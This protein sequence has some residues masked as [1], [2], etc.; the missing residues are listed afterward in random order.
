MQHRLAEQKLGTVLHVQHYEGTGCIGEVHLYSGALCSFAGGR[1]PDR[2]RLLCLWF[3]AKC[4]KGKEKERLLQVVLSW[5]RH[6]GT[7][8]KSVGFMKIPI[9]GS[10]R[11][12]IT[13]KL[14]TLGF[15]SRGCVL[16]SMHVC[17]LYIQTDSHI[18]NYV[19]VWVC[20]Y[21]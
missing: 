18:Q 6:I 11:A 7:W 1:G 2:Q 13:I 15:R 16:G 3:T 4:E 8:G 21:I 20:V 14:D 5:E 17:I 19:Y 9:P 10:P 12:H